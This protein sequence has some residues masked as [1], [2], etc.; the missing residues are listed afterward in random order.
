MRI[1]WADF[2]RKGKEK[3]GDITSEW[4]VEQLQHP[5][6]SIKSQFLWAGFFAS[7]SSEI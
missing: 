7:S 1:L 6:A 4:V 3:K 5:K 2:G